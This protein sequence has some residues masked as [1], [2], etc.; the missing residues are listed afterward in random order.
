MGGKIWYR[1]TRE[2]HGLKSRDGYATFLTDNIHQA[3]TY[4]GP[5][6]VIT[7]VKLRPNFVTEFN[8]PSDRFR[9]F[10][11]FDKEAEKL[12]SGNAILVYGVV[13][14]GPFRDE[15]TDQKAAT[16]LAQNVALRNPDR[17][18]YRIEGVIPAA[19]Y[20]EPVDDD[21]WPF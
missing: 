11:K 7:G 6:G 16:K 19:P 5:D 21:D 20:F 15:I 12:G 13:D 3:A 2:S 8:S 10:I 4:A 17:S 9:S 14:T 1:G 18:I